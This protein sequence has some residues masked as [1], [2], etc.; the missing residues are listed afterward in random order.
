[1]LVEIPPRMLLVI[2]PACLCYQSSYRI[3]DRARLADLVATIRTMGMEIEE[4]YSVLAL[5]AGP[6]TSAVV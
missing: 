1:M 5:A 4:H 3:F 6:N 2:L